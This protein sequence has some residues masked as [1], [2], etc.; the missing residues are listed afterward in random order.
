VTHLQTLKKRPVAPISPYRSS[1]FT[2][3]ELIVV[4]VLAGILA[5]VATAR[6]FNR[7]GFDAA[8]YA[9]QLRGMVR[10]G[11][12]LAIAQNR[13]VWV[14]GSVDGIALCYANAL[15]CPAASQVLP[16][17]GTNSG[18]KNTKTFCA[19]GGAYAAAWYCEGRPDGVTMI[20]SGYSLSPFYF[21]G[22]G[23][24]YVQADL[25]S[26]GTIS[27]DSTFGG[28][29]MAISADGVTSTVS[30]AQETGYVN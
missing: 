11:Q 24:P 5:A 27:T 15:P 2:F 29:S 3:V 18:N 17:T 7:T 9:E 16:P 10:Y 30:V 23:K 12:K 22:L 20:P 13:N 25:P 26:S 6:Y 14:V 1:G 19:V 4:M 21:N 8:S 28:V